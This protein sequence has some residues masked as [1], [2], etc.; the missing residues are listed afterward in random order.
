MKPATQHQNSLVLPVVDSM[1]FDPASNSM[2]L[3]YVRER[4]C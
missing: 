4:S 3:H 1:P 2:V